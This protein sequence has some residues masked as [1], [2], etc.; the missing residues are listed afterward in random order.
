MITAS[1]CLTIATP[2]YGEKNPLLTQRK[3]LGLTVFFLC[4]P[5]PVGFGIVW[6]EVFTAARKIP[7]LFFLLLF[8]LSDGIRQGRLQ[9]RH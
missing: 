9:T 8:L 7:F 1:V 3:A 5:C 6:Y 2:H 4:R